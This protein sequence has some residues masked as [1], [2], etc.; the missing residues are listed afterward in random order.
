MFEFS[1]GRAVLLASSAA[2]ALAVPVAAAAQ[3][4]KVYQFDIPSESLGQ[5]L[6]DFGLTTSQQIIFSAELVSGQN[7][8]PLRGRYTANYA[9]NNLL[10]N[11]DLTV[12]ASEAGV[13]M[14]QK[15][16]DDRAAAERPVVVAQA[17]VAPPSSPPPATAVAANETIIVTGTRVSGLTA[18]DSAAPVTVLGND[19]LTQ[20]VGSTSL[21]QALG[22]TVPS[23]N[24]QTNG[25]DLANATLSAALRKGP[26]PG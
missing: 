5:A 15:K 22:Q 7:A 25:G 26:G 20:G 19:A 3:A 4:D 8:R 16:K 21:L 9:L 18:A 13:L 10:H 1:R 12:N 23:I 14:I 24:L 2:M 6:Q 17:Q 11:S